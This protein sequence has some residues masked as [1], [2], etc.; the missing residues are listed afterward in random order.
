MPNIVANGS[1]TGK[2]IYIYGKPSIL[3]RTSRH[4][5]RQ[6]C[7]VKGCVSKTLRNSV[8]DGSVA[9]KHIYVG[10]QRV[11]LVDCH[12]YRKSLQMK[13]C[14]SIVLVRCYEISYRKALFVPGKHIKD[15]ISKTLQNIVANGSVAK[16]HIY[17]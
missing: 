1:V 7:F 9:S 2:S 5:D 11:L 8:V 13:S 3:M 4:E 17:M 14:I 10:S 6:N 12:E 16:E 15:C